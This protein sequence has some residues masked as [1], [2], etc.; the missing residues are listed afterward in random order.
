M[1]ADSRV[2]AAEVMAEFGEEVDSG[3]EEMEAAST[4]VVPAVVV[5]EVGGGQ[6]EA[7]GEAGE[8]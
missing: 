4:E 1:A 2:V 3:E 6:E 8:G 7:R 5:S